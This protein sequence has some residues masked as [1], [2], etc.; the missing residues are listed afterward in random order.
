MLNIDNAFNGI[1]IFCVEH[2][3]ITFLQ[4]LTL[5]ALRNKTFFICT[6]FST[7]Q[8][9]TIKVGSKCFNATVCATVV[10]LT[11]NEIGM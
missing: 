5:F 10:F 8:F 1:F 4:F 6:T 11:K 9:D 2:V 7:R 3:S